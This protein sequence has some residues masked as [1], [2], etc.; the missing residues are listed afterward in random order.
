MEHRCQ[1]QEFNLL[2]VIRKCF[3]NEVLYYVQFHTSCIYF[4]GLFCSPQYYKLIEECVTQ[5]VLHRSGVD[6]D[7]RHTKR[8]EIEVEPLLSEFFIYLFIYFSTYIGLILAL[9]VSSKRF[10]FTL[11]TTGYA[12]WVTLESRLIIIIIIMY[13]FIAPRSRKIARGAL[14]KK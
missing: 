8:F 3:V 6:P 4:A 14:Q 13:I 1:L 10:T 2:F 12:T 9:C 11:N 7:F 5:I